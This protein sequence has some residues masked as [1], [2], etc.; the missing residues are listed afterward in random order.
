MNWLR[1][2]R[3][4]LHC[5]LLRWRYCFAALLFLPP[6]IVAY[7]IFSINGNVGSIAD[8]LMFCFSGAIPTKTIAVQSDFQ[9]P[10]FWLL[11]FGG[12]LLINLDYLLKDLTNAGQQIIIRSNSR[13]SWFLSKCIWNIL[14]C[15]QYLAV[16]IIT[17]VAFAA[18]LGGKMS[19]IN[20][21]EL[22]AI[23]FARIIDEGIVL[24]FGQVLIN[25]VVLP[26]ATLVSLSML[27]MTL[28]LRVKPA[29]SFLICMALLITAVY[30]ESPYCIGNGAMLFRSDLFLYD[31]IDTDVAAA[32]AFAVA[33]ICSVAG[34][35]QFSKTDILEL[36]E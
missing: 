33:I 8:Y 36:E 12:G 2:F 23:V 21:P 5:G 34:V 30:V 10:V 29:I 6:C 3:H 25:T 18:A 4:D 11:L 1:L 9:L 7:S 16:G 31:G 17:I 27:Q 28:S 15:G 24:A 14:A 13:A 19:F 22:T 35:I 26:F 20:T 32:F